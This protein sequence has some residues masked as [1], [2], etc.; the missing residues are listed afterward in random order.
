LALKI[1]FYLQCQANKFCP[2]KKI[3]L[4]K[5]KKILILSHK[6]FI[7]AS[8]SGKAAVF[9]TAIRRFESSRPSVFYFAVLYNNNTILY[10]YNSR[11][12]K[13]KKILALKNLRVDARVVK[14]GGL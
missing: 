14:G 10:N 3:L 7:G 11:I 9:G 4:T 5:K 8:P 1:L 12:K 6:L 13:K 2:F